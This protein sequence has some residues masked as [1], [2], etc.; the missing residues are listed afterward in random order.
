M[1]RLEDLFSAWAQGPGTTEAEKCENAERAVKKAIA[2]DSKLSRLD[3]TVF[4]QG[5]YKVRTNV[6]QDS[7]VDVCV[8]YNGGFFESYPAGK[9][10]AD[11]GNIEGSLNFSDF[12]DMVENAL[13]SYFGTASVTQGN[14]AFDIHANTYRIDAD[15][16][17]AF[18][19]RWYTGDFNAEWDHHYHSGVA[20]FPDRGNMVINWPQ[21]TYDNG[22]SRNDSTGR[23]YKRVIRILKRLRNAMQKDK[24]AEADNV[25]SFL[26]ESLVWN[27]PL[28]AFQHNTYTDDVRYVI[29]NIFNRTRSEAP[30]S[31]LG[32]IFQMCCLISFAHSSPQQAEG[33]PALF[34]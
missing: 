34:L 1:S 5:S 3:V 19:Y 15:V 16:L 25:A 29:A 6:R 2:A 4:A 26:I 21:Q 7:D 12:K 33:Y 9:T 11:F 32:G 10:R 14:K 20:F 31:K 17:P 8:R 13:N 30:P 18:E 23:R 22:V 28:E 24:I 27:A